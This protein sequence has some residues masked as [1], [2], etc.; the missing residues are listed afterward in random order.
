MLNKYR[1]KYENKYRFIV[2]NL[3]NT[4]SIKYKLS[5]VTLLT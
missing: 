1:N 3:D 2:D 4:K 5:L